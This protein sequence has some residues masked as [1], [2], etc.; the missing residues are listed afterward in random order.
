MIEVH[1]LFVWSS[2]ASLL[3]SSVSLKIRLLH[4]NLTYRK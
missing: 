3:S 2:E 1:F 4:I